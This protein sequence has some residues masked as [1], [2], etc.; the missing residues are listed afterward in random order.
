MIWTLPW[1]WASTWPNSPP[2]GSDL[3]VSID[4]D[5]LI[6]FHPIQ[7]GG[8]QLVGRVD[9]VARGTVVLDQV[10]DLGVVILP[11]LPDE[12]H[13]RAAKGVNILVV[14]TDREDGKF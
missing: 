2:G 8:D 1:V 12:S 10:M 11:E 4:P 9:D 6:G 3:A 7:I 14:I 5:G 13:V